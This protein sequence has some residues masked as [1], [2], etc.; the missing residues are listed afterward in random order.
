MSQGKGGGPAR[1]TVN[2]KVE[3]I[4]KCRCSRRRPLNLNGADVERRAHPLGQVIMCGEPFDSGHLSPTVA[5][6]HDISLRWRLD[7]PRVHR[8]TR[9]PA[10]Q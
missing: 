4:E 9:R 10:M 7:W 3:P 8:H 2:Q 5:K 1:T 6:S